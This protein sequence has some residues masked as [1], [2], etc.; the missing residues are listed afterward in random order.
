MRLVEIF[1]RANDEALFHEKCL[2]V[3]LSTDLFVN[4]FISTQFSSKL[5]DLTL[6]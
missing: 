5:N 2:T 6:K 1:L 4:L 3:K